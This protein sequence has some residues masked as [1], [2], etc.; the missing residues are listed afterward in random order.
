MRFSSNFFL[1]WCKSFSSGNENFF[2]L[3]F[4]KIFY[5]KFKKVNLNWLTCGYVRTFSNSFTSPLNSGANRCRSWKTFHCKHTQYSL[6]MNEWKKKI[7]VKH[8]ITLH[9]TTKVKKNIRITLSYELQK[10]EHFLWDYYQSYILE[11][12]RQGSQ[13]TSTFA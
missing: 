2:H 3:K 12:Y 1:Q 6:R 13:A 5:R 7:N 8:P 9:I 4:Y 10:N 11:K